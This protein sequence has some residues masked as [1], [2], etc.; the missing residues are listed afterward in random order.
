MLPDFVPECDLS[1]PYSKGEYNKFDDQE[2]Y[3]RLSEGCPR[4]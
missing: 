4:K 1:K 3:I 2:Q